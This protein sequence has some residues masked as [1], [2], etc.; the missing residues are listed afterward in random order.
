MVERIHAT[1]MPTPDTDVDGVEV[2]AD[3][4]DAE[5]VDGEDGE[6]SSNEESDEEFGASMLKPRNT[7]SLSWARFFRRIR[8]SR[9]LL[10]L[11]HVVGGQT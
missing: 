10:R 8:L 1:A 3:E 11:H 9:R 5:D 7:C 2:G 4:V 6:D